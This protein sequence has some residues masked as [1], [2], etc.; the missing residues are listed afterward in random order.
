MTE[1]AR[2]PPPRPATRWALVGIVLALLALR[3]VGFL[4]I[5]MLIVSTALL[6]I[7]IGLPLLLAFLATLRW[8]AHL[9][10]RLAGKVL[11]SVIVEPYAAGIQG[12]VFSRLRFRFGDRSTWR[13]LAWLLEVQTIGFALQLAA[14]I[15]F[16][17]L[18]LGWWGSPLLLKTDANTTRLLVGPQDA[19]LQKRIGQ[20]ESSRALSVDHSA[21]ELR[22]IER[23]LHDGAQAQLVALGM[24]LGLAEELVGR[25]PAAATALIAE[26]R[27]SSTTALSD[28]R[29]LVRGIHPPVLADRGLAGGI[30]ALALSHPRQ[31]DLDIQLDGRPPAP[32]ESAVYFAIAEALT[33]SAKYASAQNTWVWLRHD[34][35]TLIVMVGD[36]GVGG[37]ELIPEGGLIGIE[38]RLE[39]FDGTLSM[40]SPLGGPTILTIKVPCLLQATASA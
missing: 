4:L 15:A 21:A 28:L 19:Q 7:W 16:P 2:L 30:A 31:V 27:Q 3:I 37:A 14:L 11:G 1:T 38:R 26:A 40:A 32:V 24:N 8:F 9:H 13:D 10:R 35:Q 25:D 20:L 17:F 23:D 36:D 22:R 34:G 33:N 12:G 29:S 6:I 18:P 5:A 39:A